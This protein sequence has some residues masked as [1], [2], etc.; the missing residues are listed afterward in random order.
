MYLGDVLGVLYLFIAQKNSGFPAGIILVS[1][2][3]YIRCSRYN[4]AL[5]LAPAFFLYLF[6]LI[7]M[8]RNFKQSFKKHPQHA[9]K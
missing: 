3:S 5:P 8:I 4:E 7:V 9:S 2:Y 1:F 6:I